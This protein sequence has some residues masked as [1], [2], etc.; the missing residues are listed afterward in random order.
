MT[1]EDNLKRYQPLDDRPSMTVYAGTNGAGKSELTKIL[2]HRNPDIV[3]IDADEIAKSYSHLPKNRADFAAGR[4]AVKLVR[5]CIEEGKSFSIETTLGGKN[6]LN[7]M[8]L[9]KKSGFS[10]NLYYVGLDSVDLH[11]DRVAQRVAKGGHHIP[12]EDIRRRYV[13]SLENLPQAIRLADRSFLF[14]NSNVY[15]I[16][17][18]V[19]RGQIRYQAP[20]SEITSWAKNVL[21]DWHNIQSEIHKDLQAEQ[22][23]LRNLLGEAKRK[24]YE[25]ESPLRDMQ[26][27]ERLEA[28][29]ADLNKRY[30]MMQPKGIF[31]KLRQPNRTDLQKL[32]DERNAV[33]KQIDTTRQRIPG[34]KEMAGIRT[35]ITSTSSFIEI[36]DRALKECT[37]QVMAVGNQISQRDLKQTMSRVQSHEISSSIEMDR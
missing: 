10:I 15:Q 8:Q 37:K 22:S 3:V 23:T 20:P 16:Q 33:Q 25:L 17:A 35:M 6:V 24:L 13:T 4:E 9:A 7:Q 19:Y 32:S 14:D 18:E 1:K 36:L 12:E 26:Q 11:I 5:Q 34:P 28:R 21:K 2:K 31:E 30:D 29:Q 27:L